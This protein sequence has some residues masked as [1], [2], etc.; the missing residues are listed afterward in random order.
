[1]TRSRLL[2]RLDDV[3]QIAG[4]TGRCAADCWGDWTTRSRLLGR[5]DDAQQIAG[6]TG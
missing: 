1:M 4:V 6:E 3:Q 2:G 5:L